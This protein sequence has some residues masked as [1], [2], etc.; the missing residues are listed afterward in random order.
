V[1]SL[2]APITIAAAREAGNLDE[3]KRLKA[4]FA[5]RRAAES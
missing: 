1:P 4:E 2:V 3:V 5:A